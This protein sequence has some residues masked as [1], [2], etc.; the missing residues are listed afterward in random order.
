M[1][2][3]SEKQ[4]LIH[5]TLHHFGVTTTHPEEMLDW[6]AKV[7]GMTTNFQSSRGLAFLSNDRAHY[8]MAILSLPEIKGNPDPHP[9]AKLQ[10]VAF[11]YATID[12]LLTL[13]ER[14]KGWGIEPVLTADHGPTTAFYYQD[15]H[16]RA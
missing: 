11:E 8:R 6:Y 5:P 12:D 15:N 3:E 14:L 13:W 16:E 2:Q 9:H 7:L 4:S 1:S 10:H